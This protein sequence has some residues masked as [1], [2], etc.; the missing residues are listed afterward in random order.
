MQNVILLLFLQCATSQASSAI[1]FDII[2]EAA[3]KTNFDSIKLLKLT[4]LE[5]YFSNHKI[6]IFKDNNFLM[7]QFRREKF[8]QHDT[9]VADPEFSVKGNMVRLVCGEAATI[10]IPA[11]FARTTYSA[12]L[13]LQCEK[14]SVYLNNRGGSI[15]KTSERFVGP[16]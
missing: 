15:Q 14:T 8:E 7:V 11:R 1:R 5:L 9:F 12:Q 10:S 13:E 3:E 6:Y 2:W 16:E 4:G